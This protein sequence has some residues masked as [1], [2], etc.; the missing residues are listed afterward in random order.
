MIINRIE[1]WT[2]RYHDRKV[3]IN[4]DRIQAGWNCL[5]FTKS[6]YNDLY[7]TGTDIWKYPTELHKSRSG[8]EITR[9]A[10]PLDDFRTDI[11]L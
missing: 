7:M 3:L 2:P 10:V 11:P 1:I 9:Y 5:Y 8:N 4:K 6:K